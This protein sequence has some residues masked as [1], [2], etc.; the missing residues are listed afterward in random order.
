MMSTFSNPPG[1][2]QVHTVLIVE[3]DSYWRKVHSMDV[4]RDGTFEVLCAVRNKRQA[5]AFL[6]SLIH[7]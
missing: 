4:S 5:V 3:P 2:T 6:L 7:I 1:E